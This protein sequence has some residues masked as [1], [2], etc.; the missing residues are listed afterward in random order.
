MPISLSS[1]SSDNNRSET[2]NSTNTSSSNRH[3][4]VNPL[5]PDLNSTLSSS[6]IID[7]IDY[8]TAVLKESQR[9]KQSEEFIK[10]NK[11]QHL[12]N[13]KFSNG[14]F[15][16]D[17]TFDIDDQQFRNN[18]TFDVLP[19]FEMYH[20]LQFSNPRESLDNSSLRDFP[21][22]Y[23][24]DDITPGESIRS[25]SIVT[26]VCPSLISSSNTTVNQSQSQSQSQ[27]Q[28]NSE[29]FDKNIIDNYHK[30]PQL[31]TSE[32]EISINV[33]KNLP[34]LNCK[35]DPESSLK[36]YTS[37]DIVHGYVT[38][39][40]K[41]SKEIPFNMFYVTLEGTVSV[42]DVKNKKQM[43]KKFLS[44]V[45]LSASWSYACISSSA[46]N[47]DYCAGELDHEGYQF[48]LRNDRILKPNGKY[49]KFFT[50]KFPYRLLDNNCRHSQQYHLL[51]PPS[52]GFN[53]LYKQGKYNHMMIDPI[54]NYGVY[55]K[56]SPILTNDLS[57]DTLSINYSINGVMIAED[58]RDNF[59]LKVLK[60]QE[61]FLRFIPFGFGESLFSSKTLL[62]D[63]KKII[64][65][66]LRNCKEFWE[67]PSLEDYEHLKF[68][69]LQ[70][71]NN[72]ISFPLRN[73]NDIPNEVSK[74]YKFSSSQSHSLFKKSSS[75]CCINGLITITS[76]IP[77]DGLPYIAPN[78]IQKINNKSKLNDLGKEN[79]NN[80]LETLTLNEKKIL[81]EINLKLNFQP[82]NNNFKIDLKK[83]PK[84]SNID[85][86]LLVLN[87]FS[88]GNI[89]IK[90][91]S[92]IFLSQNDHSEDEDI[93]HDFKQRFSTYIKDYKEY[94]ERFDD[95]GLS[96]DKYFDVNLVKDLNAIDNLDFDLFRLKNPFKVKFEQSQWSIEDLSKSVKIDLNLLNNIKETLIPNFQNCL[97]SRFYFLKIIIKFQG[98]NETNLKIPIRLRKF[99]EF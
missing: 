12:N 1:K 60:H 48:G 50:F 85:I 23:N 54:L 62:T 77:K 8:S 53:R 79:I 70:S 97:I 2:I 14:D 27:S 21:P 75:N 55:G 64:E 47:Q 34:Q 36:E 86:D 76:N 6:S 90:L 42:I 96:I 93:L 88:S 99:D 63:F 38:I 41:S 7:D 35:T 89:P 87:I 26:N 43:M 78:L 61:Y 84:I 17:K 58:Q 69:Q 10:L 81:T 40:N 72:H 73:E 28:P 32:I 49:K 4:I 9:R 30:L 29:F 74:I 15:V 82:S 44:M 37:G 20:S 98:G 51:L 39:K 94:K 46:I 22:D 56:G 24:Y 57:N 68:Q 71:R 33:T 95:A 66:N 3:S 45:D 80:M 52:F 31:N 11:L 59:A 13:P 83:F 67:N 25:D 19:S 18:T 16:D 65:S 91:S 5:R 92:D